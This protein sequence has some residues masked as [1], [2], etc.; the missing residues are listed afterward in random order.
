MLHYLKGETHVH[1]YRIVD[2]RSLISHVNAQKKLG[3]KNK[4]KKHENIAGHVL[5]IRR[6]LKN[7]ASS[8][9]N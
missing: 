3:K 4:K 1:I 5:V 6:R 8:Y 9:I 2:Y 7:H